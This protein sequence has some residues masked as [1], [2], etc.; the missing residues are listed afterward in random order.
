[1]FDQVG[2]GYVAAL[3]ARLVAGREFTAADIEGAPPVAMLN[4][5]MARFYWGS[6]NPVGKNLLVA[7]TPIEVVGVIADVKDHVLGG[8]P[9]RR[10]YTAYAQHVGGQPGALR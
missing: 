6:A 10:A 9:V 4:Q 7:G 2:P 3:G 1:L 8:K 5:T